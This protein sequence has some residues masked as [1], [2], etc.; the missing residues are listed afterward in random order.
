DRSRIGNLRR[1]VRRMDTV[2]QRNL[3]ADGLTCMEPMRER[4]VERPGRLLCRR[5]FKRQAGWLHRN[6]SDR[7]GCDALLAAEA[8]HHDAGD[9]ISEQ[10]A[11]LVDVRRLR[12]DQV[13]DA[14]RCGEGLQD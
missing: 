13:E 14:A 7:D 3:E 2:A 11:E 8:G 1:S 9:E 4:R 6:A 10:T 12:P 5:C